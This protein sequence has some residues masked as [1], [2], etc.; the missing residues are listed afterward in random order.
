MLSVVLLLLAI[1]LA[2]PFKQVNDDS[3]SQLNCTTVTSYQD[4]ANCVA[5]DMFLPLLIGTLLGICGILL[6]RSYI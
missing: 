3:L 5:V 6:S 1:N 4:K 2:S